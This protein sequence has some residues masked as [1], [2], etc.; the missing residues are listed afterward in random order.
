MPGTDGTDC[1]WGSF[2]IAPSFFLSTPCIN[3]ISYHLNGN[4]ATIKDLFS[5]LFKCLRVV[6]EGSCDVELQSKFV[7]ECIYNKL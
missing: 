1:C 4:N 6:A 5:F 3:G 7:G 2:N